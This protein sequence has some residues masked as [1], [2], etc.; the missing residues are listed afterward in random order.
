MAEILSLD[1]LTGAGIVLAGA[2]VLAGVRW[3][4]TAKVKQI[5]G[6]P[7]ELQAIRM[8]L[9]RITARLDRA[10]ADIANDKAG[11]RAFGAVENLVSKISADIAHL[12]AD[13]QKLSDRHD[14]GAQ[15]IWTAIDRMRAAG[16][17]AA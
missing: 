16:K 2:A 11:R 8:E 6:L 13:V 1:A 17:E 9:V 4:A 10:E 7:A 14:R 12:T 5:D 15:D 3:L